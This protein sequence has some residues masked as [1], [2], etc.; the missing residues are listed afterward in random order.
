[1]S[2]FKCPICG[3][4][5][6]DERHISIECG[7]EVREVVPDVKEEEFF[8]EVPDDNTEYWGITRRYKK[9][10]KDKWNYTQEND[11]KVNIDIEQVPVKDIRLYENKMFTIG[12][13]KRCRANFLEMF[14]Q[15]RNNEIIDEKQYKPTEDKNIPIR[16]NG[17]LV[18]I[19]EEEFYRRKNEKNR[20]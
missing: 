1:M 13:C 16:E 6:D 20:I 12:C 3:N 14:R 10:T 17:A 7:Y 5:E 2:D 9:G 11:H 15:W 8:T 19:S 4:I 18:Y